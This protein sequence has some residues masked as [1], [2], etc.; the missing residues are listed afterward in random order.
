MGQ[1]GCESGGFIVTDSIGT[2]LV[3]RLEKKSPNS[4][5]DLSLNS[6]VTIKER[7]NVINMQVSKLNLVGKARICIFKA[8]EELECCNPNHI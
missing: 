8:I 2:N 1:N 6:L 7:I 5:V 4:W 3:E